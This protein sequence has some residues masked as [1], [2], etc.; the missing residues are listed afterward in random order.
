[1]TLN[2]IMWISEITNKTG[3]RMIPFLTDIGQNFLMYKVMGYVSKN[4][5]NH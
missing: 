2:A 3:E 5:N 4:V 1:M